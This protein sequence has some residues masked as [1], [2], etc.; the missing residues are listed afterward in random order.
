MLSLLWN[1][2][3]LLGLEIGKLL[4]IQLTHEGFIKMYATDTFFSYSFLLQFYS[5]REL[6]TMYKKLFI[7]YP[8]VPLPLST[9]CSNDIP[10]SPRDRIVQL[11]Q[12][13]HDRV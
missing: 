11:R 5:F 13:S 4:Q 7:T 6:T 12:L 10:H 3:H 8:N 9:N 1:H 2:K